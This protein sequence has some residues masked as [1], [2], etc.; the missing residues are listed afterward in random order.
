RTSFI[1]RSGPAAEC[2]AERLLAGE[3]S[4]PGG[5]THRRQGRSSGMV[6]QYGAGQRAEHATDAPGGGGD[7]HVPAAQVRRCEVGEGTAEP[8]GDADLAEGE[9]QDRC[10][11][12][13]A[14]VYGGA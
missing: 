6:E 12:A 14:T 2:R 10:R 1:P 8:D 4:K 5:R 9:D 3:Q 13:R 11:I 7:A